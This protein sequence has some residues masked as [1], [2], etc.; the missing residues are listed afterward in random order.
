IQPIIIR[1]LSLEVE[2]NAR[3]S[4]KRDLTEGIAFALA[5]VLHEPQI[6]GQRHRADHVVERVKRPIRHDPPSPAFTNLDAFDRTRRFE[7]AAVASNRI[8]QPVDE[9][10]GTAGQIPEILLVED[11][12]ARPR[13]AV[14]A[15][16]HPR[17]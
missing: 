8:A 2:E 16:P 4:E 13:Y 17:G 7:I 9:H 3:D 5:E 14:D 11:G 1:K 10:V 15:M 6:D 12:L